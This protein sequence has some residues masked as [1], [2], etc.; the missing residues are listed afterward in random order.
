MTVTSNNLGAAI[1]PG[2][3][4]PTV[5]DPLE[6]WYPIYFVDDL[7]RNKLS[8]FTLLATDLVIWWDKSNAMWQVFEDKCPHRLAPLS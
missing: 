5:F 6:A 2:G 3:E 8:R 4:D 1:L 7:D